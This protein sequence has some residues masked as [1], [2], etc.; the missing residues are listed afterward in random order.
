MKMKEN[1]AEVVAASWVESI[2]RSAADGLCEELLWADRLPV[3]VWL[4]VM[5]AAFW[6]SSTAQH[7]QTQCAAA[8]QARG[9]LS[10]PNRHPD[11]CNMSL[12]NAR[13]VP[14]RLAS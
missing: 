12:R 3:I 1:G 10:A 6:L 2:A 7:T 5:A 14:R 11:E 4:D 8:V 13:P 9:Q